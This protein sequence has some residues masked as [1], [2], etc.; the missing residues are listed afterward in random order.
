VRELL[1]CS[2]LHAILELQSET[3]HPQSPLATILLPKRSIIPISPE[4][5]A[6]NRLDQAQRSIGPLPIMGERCRS[7]C[8]SPT[9]EV[10]DRRSD[11]T[12]AD[13]ER[14]PDKRENDPEQAVIGMIGWFWTDDILLVTSFLGRS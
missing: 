1:R 13:R 4:V 11:R 5:V 3:R 2:F 7:P 12:A 14:G 9:E 6:T 8:R 10:S